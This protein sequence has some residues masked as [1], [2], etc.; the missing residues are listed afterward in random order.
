MLNPKNLKNLFSIENDFFVKKNFVKQN[1][2][3]KKILV[4]KVFA[5]KKNFGQENILVKKKILVQNVLSF[6]QK[7]WVGLT[8]GGGLV[9]LP[10]KIVGLKLSKIVVSCPKRVFV[11]IR[12][13][14]VNHGGRVGDPTPRK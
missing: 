10:Q 13:E 4:K 1:S 5:H 8:L 14:R 9:P 2:W 3:S 6:C 11:Q 12:L 7:N